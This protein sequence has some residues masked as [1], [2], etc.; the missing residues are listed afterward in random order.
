MCAGAGGDIFVELNSVFTP[1][2]SGSFLIFVVGVALFT[3]AA[4]E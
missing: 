1:F 4:E 3:T 2:D